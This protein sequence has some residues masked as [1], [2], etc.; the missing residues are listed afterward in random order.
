MT[1]EITDLKDVHG[2]DR[3]ETILLD[4][5]GT[6]LDLA[7]DN[8]FWR[9]LVPRCYARQ[10][11]ISADAAREH[12][13]ELYAGREG[14]LDWYCIDFWTRQLGLNLIELKAASSHR[15][16]FLPGA[17][18]FLKLARRK[19]KRLVLVTNAHQYTLK[20]KREVA[21]LN[22]WI[23]EFVS[24]HDIGAPKEQQI[25][26]RT[27]E[28]QLAFD[29]S[30]TLF[31]DDSLPVL[32]AAAEYGLGGVIA[33]RRPDSRHPAREISEHAGIDGVHHWVDLI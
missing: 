26:W 25:F 9:D 18:E 24:S 1:Q 4:M 29:P 16:G 30:T 31:I 11:N 22:N 15:I 33:V 6:L 10:C 28:D 3:Y 17:K 27:L 23:D 5:D 12:I 21:G 8:Y 14:T 32:N 13:Y 20:V 19:G 2:L 7:F